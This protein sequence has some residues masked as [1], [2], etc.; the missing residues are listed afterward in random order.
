MRGYYRHTKIIVSLG[1][2]TESREQI[3]KLIRSGVDMIRLSM[4]FIGTAQVGEIV[5][6]IRQVSSE[7]E[8]HVAIM[9][10]LQGPE[11]HTGIL[12]HDLALHVDQEFEFFTGAPTPGRQGVWV[13]HPGLPGDV[14]VGDSILVDRGS[15]RLEVKQK[16]GDRVCCIVK[17]PGT[18]GSCKNINLPGITPTMPPITDADRDYLAQGVAAGID[19]VALSFA[20]QPKDID[21]LRALLERHGSPARI[22]AKIEDQVGLRNLDGIVAKAD[23]IMVARGDL[24][25]EIDDHIL[26]LVQARIVESCHAHGKPV[27]IATHLLESMVSSPRPTRAEITDVTDAIKSMVDALMLSTETTTGSYPLECVTVLLNILESVEP[28]EQRRLNEAMRLL[29]PKS[30]ML[31]SAAVLAQDLDRSGIVVFSR[32]GSLPYILG[33]LRPRSVP[34][35]AFTDVEAVFRHLLL[36]WGVEPF[37]MEF[38]DDPEITIKNAL[39]YLRRRNWCDPGTWLVVITNALAH[40]A[41]ID[42]IQLRQVE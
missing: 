6:R 24:A 17:T 41:I 38:S 11:M 7:V 40:G 34:I 3:A 32:S 30:K 33:A 21:E 25:V 37:L 31:R 28:K 26:P 16:E 1:P 18:L 12:D 29:T 2:A 13:N 36:P 39:A 4:A 27:I 8:R 10:D 20:R 19:F 22:I 5:A 42:T 23:G 35:Y 9:L 15:I 14:S